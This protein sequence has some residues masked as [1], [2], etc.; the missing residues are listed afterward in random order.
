MSVALTKYGFGVQWSDI[1][2]DFYE[3]YYPNMT[4]YHMHEYYEISLII[5]GNVNILLN[6]S[7]EH[8]TG[9]KVV[10]LRPFTP[11]Y[12]YCEPDILYK[13]RNVLFSPDFI[14]DYIP[15]WQEL[16]SVFR[17]NG[18]VLTLSEEKCA[19]YLRLI[20][21]IEKEND[22]FRKKLILLYFISLIADN[23]QAESNFTELP[24]F[25][26]KALSYIS[27]HYS[28]KVV[29]ADLAEKLG[30]GRTTLMSSFKKYTGTTLNEYL[31]RC[32]L[33][34]AVAELKKGR[35]VGETAEIC[36]FTDAPNLIR[37]FKRH[38]GTTPVKYI[39]K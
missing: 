16:L 20:D 4:D 11:H 27:T 17:E 21:S 19:E 15:E 1:R 30:V 23:M 9:S 36:G 34:N 7:M 26:T 25:V 38:F 22:R 39:K 35:T 13:R 32:R 2:T 29:A 6:D 33:K 24:I 12:I 10:L 5:S 28:E 37:C 14:S 8:S 31:A 3:G 18:S